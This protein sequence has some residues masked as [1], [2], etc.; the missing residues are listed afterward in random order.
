M[1]GLT[2]TLFES[3]PF[4]PEEEKAAFGAAQDS[5]ARGL[6]NF[7]EPG[8]GPMTEDPSAFNAGM[9]AVGLGA[10][11]VKG[12]AKVANLGAQRIKK[13]VNRLDEPMSRF[14]EARVSTS[15]S[16]AREWDTIATLNLPDEV[17]YMRPGP[18]RAAVLDRLAQ[19]NAFA[20]RLTPARYRNQAEE[21]LDRYENISRTK[22]NAQLAARSEVMEVVEGLPEDTRKELFE[23]LMNSRDELDRMLELGQFELGS[24][25]EIA[26]AFS[27]TEELVRILQELM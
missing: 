22:E 1:A 24:Y 14:R 9:L 2:S 7:A 15:D 4:V 13:L 5:A 8:F 26:Q 16:M 20:S 11:P 10:A 12:A 6:F 21:A 18:E 25:S 3:S 19:Q 27:K 23:Y 17:L